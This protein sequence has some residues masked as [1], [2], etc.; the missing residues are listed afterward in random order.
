MLKLC[1]KHFFLVSI[2]FHRKHIRA[3]DIL[4]VEYTQY[5]HINIYRHKHINIYAHTG[6]CHMDN[7]KLYVKL[8]PWLYKNATSTHYEMHGSKRNRETWKKCEPAMES[9]AKW[10]LHTKI[11]ER[12]QSHPKNK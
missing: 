8:V 12:K 10:R 11:N 4:S 2:F 5:I 9:R 7:I 1:S 3:L 6:W